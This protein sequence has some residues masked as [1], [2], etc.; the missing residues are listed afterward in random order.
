MCTTGRTADSDSG[1]PVSPHRA[2]RLPPRKG[3]EAVG[4]L[5]EGGEA[6]GE[7]G[8]GGGGGRGVGGGVMFM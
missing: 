4:S 2:H 1:P 7:G 3:L 5:T 8:G 6:S